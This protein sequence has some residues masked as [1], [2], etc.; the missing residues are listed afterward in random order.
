MR[1]PAIAIVLAVI[2]SIVGGCA[3]QDWIESTLV[4]VDVTGVWEGTAVGGFM[5]GLT[6]RLKLVQRGAAVEGEYVLSGGHTAPVHGTVNGDF[7]RLVLGLDGRRH[8]EATIAGDDMTGVLLGGIWD[9]S[10]RVDIH[11]TR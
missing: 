6:L 7:V 5:G 8:L 4:T 3:Q 1:V 2:L 10:A 9:S 11:R